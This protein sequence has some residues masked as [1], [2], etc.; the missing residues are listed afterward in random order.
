VSCTI[1]TTFTPT[2]TGPEEGILSTELPRRTPEVTLTGTGVTTPQPDIPPEPGE[3]PPFMLD[4]DA[5]KKQKLDER[6]GFA[7]QGPRSCL[8]FFA[9][10]KEDATMA[11][12]GGVKVGEVHLVGGDRRKVRLEPRRKLKDRLATTGKATVKVQAEA[13]S[14]SGDTDRDKVTVKLRD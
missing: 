6:C 5:K 1:N 8:K 7:E 9:E 4:L 12:G 2:S 3:P 10:A 13:T 11:V 14:D